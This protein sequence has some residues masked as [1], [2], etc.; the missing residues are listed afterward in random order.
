MDTEIDWRKVIIV[1]I[2]VSGVAFIFFLLGRAS[3]NQVALAPA[4][5]PEQKTVAQKTETVADQ[6]IPVKEVKEEKNVYKNEAYGFGLRFLMQEQTMTEC[7]YP[8]KYA[9][10]PVKEYVFSEKTVDCAGA[11]KDHE[12]FYAKQ[13]GQIE[14]LVFDTDRCS[15]TV[16]D[17]TEKVFCDKYGAT[18]KKEGVAEN[19]KWPKGHWVKSEQFLTFFTPLASQNQ[20]TLVKQYKFLMRV[21]E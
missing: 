4:K 10:D 14:A 5:V 1:F 2:A 15:D 21:Q 3:M 18:E 7:E 8:S 9:Y 6:Q 11:V 12:A 17:K 16:T 13:G 19:S 20:E